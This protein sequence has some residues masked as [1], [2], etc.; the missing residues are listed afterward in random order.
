[1]TIATAL[2]IAMLLLLLGDVESVTYKVK[3]ER[4]SPK[5]PWL[6]AWQPQVQFGWKSAWLY[7]YNVA[8]IPLPKYPGFSE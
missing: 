3:M 2:F 8:H 6:S 7:N 4:L 1:M 5:D